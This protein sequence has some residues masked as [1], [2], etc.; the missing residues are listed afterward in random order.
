MDRGVEGIEAWFALRVRSRFE[1]RVEQNIEG[2]GIDAFAPCYEAVRRY[3]NSVKRTVRLPLFPGYVFCRMESA[4]RMAV[5]TVPGVVDLVSFGGRPAQ[6]DPTELE[7]IRRCV[8]SASA[9]Q[10]WGYLNAGDKVRIDDGPLRGLEGILVRA[11]GEARLVV[12]VS[13][14]SRSLAVDVEKHRVSP[15]SSLASPV[16][17][18]Q[19]QTARKPASSEVRAFAFDRSN[20]S[21]VV[22]PGLAPSAV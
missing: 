9:I 20:A 1:K 7:A 5:L 13:L 15:V 18:A 6:V 4:N 16:R 3:P 12:S 21:C 14:L 8:H 17:R 22:Q 19:A 11:S 10:P 2:K